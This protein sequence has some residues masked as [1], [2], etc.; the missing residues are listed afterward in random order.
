M[1]LERVTSQCKPGFVGR[2]RGLFPTA[3][4][5]SEDWSQSVRVSLASLLKSGANT[6]AIQAANT[7]MGPTGIIVKLVI[8]LQ[9]GQRSELRTDNLWK[10]STW[11]AAN[12]ASPTF[13]DQG[14]KK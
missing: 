14:R 2:R 8:V 4:W 13:D 1:D 7:A 9:D 11:G 6:L 12:G 3:C 10:D 5:E